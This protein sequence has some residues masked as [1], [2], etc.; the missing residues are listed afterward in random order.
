MKYK[1]LTVFLQPFYKIFT[2][3]KRLRYVY[4]VRQPGNG[5]F[6][7]RARNLQRYLKM[8]MRNEKRGFL[9]VFVVV[10]R[11]ST[12]VR[13]DLFLKSDWLATFFEKIK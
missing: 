8:C 3:A 2:T 5:C 10:V 1:Q 12:F 6:R 13:S 4:V 11:R 7:V 9:Y